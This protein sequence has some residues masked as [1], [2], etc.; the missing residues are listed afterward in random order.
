VQVRVNSLVQQID[1]GGVT[2]D[3]R[4]LR[5]GTVLWAAGVSASPA[6]RWLCIEPDA[7][8]RARVDEHLR[9]PGHPNVFVIGDAAASLAWKGQ[10]VPGLAPAAK[11]GGEH[12]AAFIRAQLEMRPSPPAFAY[13]HLGSLATIGRRSAV[14]DFGAVKLWGAPAWW[15]W[16]AVHVL[17]LSG[18]RNRLAVIIAWIWAYVTFRGGTRLIIGSGLTEP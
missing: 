4:L 5:A 3:G 1:S 2:I 6:A 7:S 10:P 9:A 16:G 18:L 13:R 14:A 17:S 15:L 8:G 11:Q 12:V